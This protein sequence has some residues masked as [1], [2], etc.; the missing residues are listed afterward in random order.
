MEANRWL[1]MEL[2]RGDSHAHIHQGWM[3]RLG[4]EKPDSM[5]ST[6]RHRAPR[7]LATTR[8]RPRDPII[9]KSVIAVLWIR[10]Q[11]SQNTNTLQTK[12]R[13]QLQCSMSIGMGTGHG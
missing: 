2:D 4:R 13:S 6:N 1:S 7:A 3:E 8:L 9:L 11:S 10:K 5:T 12:A